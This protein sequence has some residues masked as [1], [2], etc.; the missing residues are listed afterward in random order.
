MI[1]GIGLNKKLEHSRVV[2]YDADASYKPDQMLFYPASGV[3]SIYEVLLFT[4]PGD[5]PVSAPTKFLLKIDGGNPGTDERKGTIA[6]GTPGV[7]QPITF[8]TAFLAAYDFIT[9]FCKDGS[10]NWMPYAINSVTLAGFDITV[11]D[12]GTLFYLCKLR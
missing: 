12:I 11:P 6:L 3:Q 8:T 9:I 7:A 4:D 5:T 2:N 1:I 10:G